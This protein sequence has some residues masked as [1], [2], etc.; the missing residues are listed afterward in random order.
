MSIDHIKVMLVEDE[1]NA[2]ATMRAM[3]A[4]MGIHQVFEAKDG[5]SARQLIDMDASMV[6]MVI[7][8]WNMP[9]FTGIELL[10]HMRSKNT[11]I[12]VL[13]VTGRND[14]ASVKEAKDN[15]VSGYI[16]KPFSMK[17]LEAKIKVI[18]ERQQKNA[19]DA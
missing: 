1:Q 5:D 11:N 13:M 4:E 10:K 17:E 6:D 9:N 14:I 7:S 8:D 3:L 2:R 12:P 19:N 16:R 18:W 15:Q